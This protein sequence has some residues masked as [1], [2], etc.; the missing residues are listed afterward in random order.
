MTCYRIL[1]FLALLTSAVTGA[2]NAQ[3]TEV[4]TEYL[5]T[6]LLLPSAM[7]STIRYWF[8]NPKPG[9]WVKGPR[10][11]G[12]VIAPT[13]DWLRAMPSGVLRLDVRLLIETDDGAYVYMTYGG[14]IAFLKVSLDT[15]A[16]GGTVTD[17]TAPYFVTAPTFQTSAEKYGWLNR[18]QAIGK[19]VKLKRG[20]GAYVQYD[21]FLV[22]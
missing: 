6:F 5:M 16:E 13:A 11:N 22:R 15:L 14:V 21:I 8:V 7:R 1:T 18:V 9:G 10:F 4:N 12:K 20:G 2:A 3:T 19:M 17:K